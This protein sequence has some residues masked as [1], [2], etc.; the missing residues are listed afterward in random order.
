MKSVHFQASGSDCTW[1]GFYLGFGSV[2]SV[3]FLFS[4]LVAWVLGGMQAREQRP[5]AIVVWALFA[6]QLATTV[7]VYR[8]F[9]IA[10]MVSST[11]ITALLGFGCLRLARAVPSNDARVSPTAK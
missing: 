5:W 4:A 6:A 1:F 2:D 3:F 10:P 7:F 11:A 8:Y 9:F